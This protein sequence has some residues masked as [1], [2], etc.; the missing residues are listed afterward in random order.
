[1]VN[2]RKPYPFSDIDDIMSEN[3]VRRDNMKKIVI[4]FVAGALLMASG[5]VLADSVS[6][7]GKKI[8]GEAKVVLNGKQL[9]NAV[10]SEGKSY[11]PVRDIAEALGASASYTKGVITIDPNFINDAETLRLEQIA[12]LNQKKNKL[13][14]D[15]T[16]FTTAIQNMEAANI[17]AQEDMDKITQEWAKATYKHTIET[18]NAGIATNEKRIADID[19]EVAAI[20][21]EIA[22]LQ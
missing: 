13:I 12:S 9:S 5:Q 2:S 1:M 19:I 10:I 8:E 14:A 3:G 17:K 11:A 4:A 16:R 18:N 21:A 7:I 20:D 22:A 6:K 15:K